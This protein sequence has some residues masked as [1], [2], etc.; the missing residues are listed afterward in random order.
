MSASLTGKLNPQPQLS[1][2]LNNTI[3]SDY[4]SIRNKP[5]LGGVT[6][7][8]HVT[9]SKVGIRSVIS[10]HTSDWVR[11]NARYRITILPEVHGCGMYSFIKGFERQTDEGTENAFLVYKRLSNG[12]HVIY[13]DEPFDG[14]IFLE[15]GDDA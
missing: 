11:E 4:D 13:S 14:T 12:S 7:S 9:L 6:L 5:T 2:V 3:S 15:S 10:F 8:G 1:G